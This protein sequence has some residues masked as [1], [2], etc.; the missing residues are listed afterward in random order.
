MPGGSRLPPPRGMPI[1]PPHFGKHGN[2]MLGMGGGMGMMGMGIGMGG[3]P[4]GSMGPG[5]VGMMGG[6]NIGGGGKDY[7]AMAS[8][9]PT[10]PSARDP[11]PLR[12]PPMGGRGYA[13]SVALHSNV[14]FGSRPMASSSGGGKN[15]AN[16]AHAGA[17][18]SRV[19]VGGGDRDRE[20]RSGGSYADQ[21]RDVRNAGRMLGAA[22]SG[23]LIRSGGGGGR[24]DRGGNAPPSP[25]GRDQFGR[26]RE[27]RGNGPNVRRASTSASNGQVSSIKPKQI[28][29]LVFVKLLVGLIVMTH[30]VLQRN[31]NAFIS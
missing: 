23:G 11:F 31:E 24:F 5:G 25:P 12:G 22:L 10:P 15:Y 17:V 3:V 20:R 7:A 21:A 28:C 19:G 2:S 29:I 26:E 14:T 27:W 16:F 6:G 4:V 30:G 13:S 8:V 18:G 1:A 9:A